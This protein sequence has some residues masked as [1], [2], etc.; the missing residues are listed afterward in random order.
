MKK[1]QLAIAILTGL[2]LAFNAFAQDDLTQPQPSPEATSVPSPDITVVPQVEPKK[3]GTIRIGVVTIKAQLK[4]NGMDQDVSDVIRTRWYSFL[5][6]PSVEVVPIDSRVPAQAN[7][8]AEQ[9]QC[10]YVL[11]SAVSQK[12]KSSI[13][14]SLINVAI[15]VLTSAIPANEGSIATNSIKNTIQDGAK[16]AAKNMANQAASRISAQDQ[17]TLE[18]KFAKVN[19]SAPLVAKALK[20]KAKADGEDVFSTLIEQAAGQILEVALKG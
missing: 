4:Q 12:A 2:I 5:N 20:A 6:G 7:I 11:Y 9:K 8:E 15:P 19:M 1:K 13:F 14:G 3:D 16:D 17:I 10:D 18:Y